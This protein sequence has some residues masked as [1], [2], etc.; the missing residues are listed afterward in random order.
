MFASDEAFLDGPDETESGALLAIIILP[1][2][3]EPITA[4]L[5]ESIAE[6]DILRET[7]ETV[8]FGLS[9]HQ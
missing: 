1:P 5:E 4:V 7:N 9:A 3:S 2:S 8:R 6:Y